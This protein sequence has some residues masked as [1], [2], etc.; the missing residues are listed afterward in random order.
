MHKEKEDILGAIK[1]DS[2]EIFRQRRGE[3]TVIFIYRSY[4]F[5]EILYILDNHCVFVRRKISP[6]KNANQVKF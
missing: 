5:S 6:G 4:V 2:L 3:E 1:H